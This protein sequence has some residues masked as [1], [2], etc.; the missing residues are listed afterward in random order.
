MFDVCADFM[1]EGVNEGVFPAGFFRVGLKL[2]TSFFKLV[3]E[4]SFND[5]VSCAQSGAG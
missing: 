1:K 2:G 3:E 5:F 4:K